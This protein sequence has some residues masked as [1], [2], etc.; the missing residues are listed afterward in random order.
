MVVGGAPLVKS[1]KNHVDSTIQLAVDMLEAVHVFNKKNLL[2]GMHGSI[3]LVLRVICL[4]G[5]ELKIRVGINH[6]SVIGG[7]IGK[8]KWIYDMW[9][10]ASMSHASL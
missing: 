1:D 7:V 4:S 3:R 5:T 10:D 9:G 8:S 2:N 6:G